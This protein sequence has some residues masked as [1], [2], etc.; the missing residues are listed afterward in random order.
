MLC[1]RKSIAD[2]KN[3]TGCNDAIHCVIYADCDENGDCEN[4]AND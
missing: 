2:Y 3:F 4:D 1:S